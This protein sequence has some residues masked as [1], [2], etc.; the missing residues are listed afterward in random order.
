MIK[1]VYELDSKYR[2]KI[3]FLTNE[4]ASIFCVS[5]V[6]KRNYFILPSL[7]KTMKIVLFLLMAIAT[8]LFLGPVMVSGQGLENNT[9][10]NSDSQI[11]GLSTESVDLANSNATN[12]VINST[13]DQNASGGLSTESV[14]ES[15][16]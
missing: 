11:G 12:Q 5:V 13:N 15:M 10:N 9:V 14:R 6:I 8:P 16:Y 7:G 1:Q 4:N 2:C 3:R